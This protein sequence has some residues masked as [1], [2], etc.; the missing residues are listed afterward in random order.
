MTSSATASWTHR[1]VTL[2][3]EDGNG[4]TASRSFTLHLGTGLTR[5][6][7]NY[8]EALFLGSGAFIPSDDNIACP[9]WNERL[10]PRSAR[11]RSQFAVRKTGGR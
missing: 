3:V 10:A 2:D 6:N 11:P 8:I 4:G 5:Y 9:S 1:T 7:K